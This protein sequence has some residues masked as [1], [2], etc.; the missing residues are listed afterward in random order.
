MV[1]DVLDLQ[2]VLVVGMRVRQ[3]SELLRQVETVGHVLGRDKVLRH[4]DAVVQI[5]YLVTNTETISLWFIICTNIFLN[6][7]AK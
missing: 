1:D 5:P 7:T 2:L 4:F 6:P 3:F